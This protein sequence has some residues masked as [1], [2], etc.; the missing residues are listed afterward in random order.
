MCLLIVGAG[1]MIPMCFSLTPAVQPVG[2]LAFV[3]LVA[4]RHGVHVQTAPSGLG[5]VP[6]PR[7]SLVPH[8]LKLSEARILPSS[9]QRSPSEATLT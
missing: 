6:I 3:D 2:K 4:A 1:R 7:C 8:A 9:L 5:C